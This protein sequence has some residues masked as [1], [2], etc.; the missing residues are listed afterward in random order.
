MKIR[1]LYTHPHASQMYITFF[2]QMNIHKDL[3]ENNPCLSKIQIQV[4]LQDFV[5]VLDFRK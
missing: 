4:I 3:K 5:N 1:S 2:L